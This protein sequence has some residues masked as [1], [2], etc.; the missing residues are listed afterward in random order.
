MNLV[1]WIYPHINIAESSAANTFA[2][3]ED[4]I[5]LNPKSDFILFCNGEIDSFFSPLFKL[6]KKT[7]E[8]HRVVSDFDVFQ[9]VELKKFN[10]L[11]FVKT[12]F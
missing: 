2:W 6:L 4:E 3:A 11:F 12:L 5:N 9:A 8:K 7:G 1:V 10:V